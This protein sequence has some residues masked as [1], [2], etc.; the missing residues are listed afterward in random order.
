MG[1]KLFS[2]RIIL[3][4]T[5]FSAVAHYGYAQ[6]RV[7]TGKVE[8]QDDKT[9]LPG[10][11]VVIKGTSLGSVT[12]ID[13][14]YSLTI[15]GGDDILT[16]SFLGYEMSE[17]VVGN[18]NQ[19]N[20]LLTS[21]SAQLNELIVLGYSEKKKSEITGAVTNVSSE[22]LKDVTGSNIEY[23]LQGKVA[24]VQVST[25]TGAPGAAAEIRIRG[26]TSINADRGPLVVVDGIIGGSYN[27]NDVE[28]ITVLKDAGAIA[29]YGSRANSGVIIVTTKRGN[30]EKPEITYRATG[31]IRQITTGNFK[32]M[33]ASQLYDAERLMFSSSAVFNALRPASKKNINTDWVNL[34]YD[35]GLIQNHNLSAR[36]KSGKVSYYLAGDFYDEKGT[37]LSTKYTRYNLRTNI[38]YQISDKVTLT[39]N[40]NAVQDYSNSYHWR[41]PYQPFLYLPYDSPYD[42][43]G[44]YAYI[45]ATNDAFLTRDKNNIFQSAHYN[46][47]KTKG[48][49]MNG[50]MVL[51]ASITP[52]LK[53]QSRNRISTAN[54]RSD[55][56][57][58]SRTIEG[59]AN[60]GNLSFGVSDGVSLISTNL[61]KA[62]K[63]F[64]KHH[65]GGFIGFEG[66]K[67]TAN[68]AGASGIG[69]VA[70]IKIPGGIA[71]PQ[72]ISGSK[73]VSKSMSILTDINYDF[74]E[75]YFISASFRRD[76]SSLFGANKRWGNFGAV[77]GSWLLNK[78]AFFSSFNKS[79][80]LLKLRGSFGIVGNDAIP[81][82]QYL[83]KYNFTTQYNNGSAGYPETLPNPNLG[84]EQTKASNIGLDITL[85]KKL[86]ITIDAFYKNTD[87][88]LLK[89]QLP[90][91]QGIAEVFKNTGRILNKGIELSIGGDVISKKNFKWNINFNVGTAQNEVKELAVGTTSV[92]K[93]YDGIKQ[94][95]Q[96]GHDVNSW[97]LPKWVG[98]NPAN[99]DPQ[100]EKAKVD[101]KGQ[102]IGYETTNIY[103]E[104]SST[105]S[106][107]FV[108]SATPKLFGG[109]NSLFSFKNWTL[110]IATAYQYGNKVYHRTREFIDADGANFNFNMMTL[111]NGWSRWQNV[112]DIATHPKPQFGGNLQSNK[113]SSRYLED[114]SF[115]R[116]RNINLTYNLPQNF[117]SKVNIKN[118]SVFV[119]ADNM[120]T[121]SKFSGL[122]PEVPSFGIAGLSDFK[123][124]LSKQYL[125]GLQFSF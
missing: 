80:T 120:F 116:I 57:E 24:G 33:D 46:D 82:F 115:L 99:G 35:K 16:F 69:I 75:T 109:F 36:G 18:Q 2:L 38:D 10:V 6:K 64:G 28:N 61:I 7:I 101:S 71:S 105:A 53:L 17:I 1:K 40:L 20:I 114:G 78:E 76:G 97:Y 63:D 23:M 49:N 34:A 70:G 37:L 86:D 104:A 102:V 98:V 60:N 54:Y 65:I 50:D 67:Y 39:T 87:N 52:W 62:S 29:L 93:D 73:T 84:W 4:F 122:D 42:A 32:M 9:A 12:D 110:N 111:A 103:A 108:G 106:L 45:D 14:R 56:Y 81:P 21:S 59:K 113:P 77:S 95:I 89:V 27:P 100:W 47:Y 124:P 90:P 72:S 41:W 25:A 22:K 51:T 123:Y 30:S 107:Q 92:N 44:N 121:F 119:S 3:L 112:G 13:G 66:Q 26:N 68:E 88:L 15:N 125:F 74:K 19:I 83:A 117:L 118:A 79:F 55:T 43:Q 8:S 11:S 96:V 31:G 5:L 85:F 48:L 58:D 94:S 91:S